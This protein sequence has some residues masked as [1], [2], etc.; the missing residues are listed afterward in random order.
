MQFSIL[1][2]VLLPALSLAAPTPD[3]GPSDPTYQK[4]PAAVADPDPAR[5]GNNIHFSASPY[6]HNHYHPSPDCNYGGSRNSNS[7]LNTCYRNCDSPNC[8]RGGGGRRGEA[9]AQNSIE[10]EDRGRGACVADKAAGGDCDGCM[11]K[12]LCGFNYQFGGKDDCRDDCGKEN[13]SGAV[14]YLEINRECLLWLWMIYDGGD[15]V[16]LLR[17]YYYLVVDGQVELGC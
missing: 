7:N 17:Y 6:E 13:R 2:A 5:A 3:N 10:F 4:A 15:D 12:E 1:I 16:L 8:C 14:S 9:N 11:I